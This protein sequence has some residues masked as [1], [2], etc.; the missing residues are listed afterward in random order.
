MVTFGENPDTHFFSPNRDIL[1]SYRMLLEKKFSEGEIAS[2]LGF[3]GFRNKKVADIGTRDGRNVDAFRH[4]GARDVYGIDPNFSDLDL[5]VKTG[6]LDR[7]HAI[8][9][10]LDQIL[11]KMK[12]YFDVAAVLNFSIPILE[13]DQFVEALYDVLSPNGEVVMT[14]VEGKTLYH[15][16]PILQRYF[17]VRESRLTKGTEDGAHAYL[18]VATKKPQNSIYHG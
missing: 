18:V 3:H 12:G 9:K 4:L 1:E 5:A 16:L 7:K 2:S 14:F 13:R 10:K 11:P 17:N 6:K 8:G 15:T